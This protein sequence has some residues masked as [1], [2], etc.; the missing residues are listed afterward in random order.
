MSTA[1]TITTEAA[2]AQRRAEVQYR[3]LASA[4]KV[5]YRDFRRAT[6]ER[7]AVY[8]RYKKTYGIKAA[9]DMVDRILAEGGD[10]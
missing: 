4:V 8:A 1:D 10:A 3:I 7:A 9:R 6:A 5:A 2:A